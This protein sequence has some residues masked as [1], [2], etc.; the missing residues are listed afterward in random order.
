MTSRIRAGLILLLMLLAY[1]ALQAR[2]F[3]NARELTKACRKIDQEVAGKG[4]EIR[5]PRAKDALL[6]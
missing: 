1:P 6:C 3:E 4:K 5:I 2:A